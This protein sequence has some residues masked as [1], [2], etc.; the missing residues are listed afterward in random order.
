VTLEQLRIF[1]AVAERLHVTQA[2]GVLNMTQSAVSAA[3][4]A[5]ESRHGVRLF[6]RVGRGVE[7]NAAGRLFLDEART[8]LASAA[9][10]E[11][12]LQDLAELRRGSLSIHA[13]QTIA[14]YWLPGRL[15]AYRARHAGI[16]VK[17]R[18]N[19]TEQVARAV[20][21]G[22]ADLG[23]VE[24]V[25]ESAVLEERLLPGDALAIVVAAGHPWAL[26]GQVAPAELAQTPWVL[27]E[28][29]SGTRAEFE[30]AI[31]AHGL[32]LADLAV[33]LE[34]PSNEAICAAVEAGAGAAAISHLVSDA[35]VSAGRL[36]R[37]GFPFPARAFHAVWHRERRL[38]KATEAFL[39][40]VLA[41]A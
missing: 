33:A 6:D 41:S 1:V 35:A 7:L 21:E 18:I 24:G 23:F 15:H 22:V 17:V 3:I 16:S 9:A 14:N 36:R 39:Q 5:L 40:Q 4:A 8:V 38:T 31:A 27:R 34:L 26:R 37:I 12:A 13:S 29:G 28:P 19:N 2:A 11:R 10:A 25:I 20:I 32:S 30:D